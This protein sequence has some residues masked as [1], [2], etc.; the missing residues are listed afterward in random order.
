MFLT[1]VVM[2]V[3]LRQEVCTEFRKVTY[4][5]LVNQHPQFVLD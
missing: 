2:L 1:V 5:H 3:D 4:R